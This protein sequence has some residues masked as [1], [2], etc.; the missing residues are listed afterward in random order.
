M[1]T[2]LYYSSNKEP[3]EDKIV[4]RLKRVNLPIISVTHKPLDLGNNICVGE[5]PVCYGNLFKQI[6]IGLREV[7]T[8]YVITAESDVLYPPEYFTFKPSYGDCWRYDNVWVVY[9]GQNKAL[10]KRYSDGAQIMRT[11]WWLD[12]INASVQ[13]EWY[14]KGER[15]AYKTPGTDRTLT[16]TGNPVI[17]FKTPNNVSK[18][19]SVR[20]H[21]PVSSLPYWGDI[22]NL[23]IA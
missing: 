7:K 5:H 9:Q 22:H 2:V 4:E 1:V 10:F 8:D 14:N 17:T 11:A 15:S 13:E 19:T 21:P 16:W 6:Q 20:K 18:M 12:K 23:E 3:F